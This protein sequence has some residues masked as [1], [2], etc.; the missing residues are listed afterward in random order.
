MRLSARCRYGLRATFDIAY[1]NRG[2]PTQVREMSKRQGA[3]PRMLEQVLGKLKAAGLVGSQRGRRGGYY[4]ARP[5]DEISLGDIVRACDGSLR[6]TVGQLKRG[7]AAPADRAWEDAERQVSA[8]FDGVTLADI[9]HRT[10]REGI[11]RATAPLSTM[12]SI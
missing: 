1:H 9:C 8:A 6:L 3:S 10:E 2:R 7:P 11:P 12:Y 4:L 5:A